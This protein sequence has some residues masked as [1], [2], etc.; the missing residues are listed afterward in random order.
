MRFETRRESVFGALASPSLIEK[1]VRACVSTNGLE[2][3]STV[4][5][6]GSPLGCGWHVSAQQTPVTFRPP[7]GMLLPD[8][9]HER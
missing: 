6:D 7:V 5:P 8:E 4:T 9:N 3:I 1:L 2:P